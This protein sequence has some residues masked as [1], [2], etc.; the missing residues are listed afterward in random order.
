MKKYF[1]YVAILA[2]TLGIL[3]GTFVVP[4]AATT[5][6]EG[7]STWASDYIT[8]YS[9]W[10]N[11]GTGGK[12]YVYFDI[13]A[14]RE[15]ARVGAKLIVVQKLDAGTWK[16]VQTTTGTLSNGLLLANDSSHT[17]LIIYA[18]TP[19]N[20]YRGVVTVYSGPVSGGD[21]RI[22]TTN[23]VVAKSS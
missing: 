12:V 8:S 7:N 3:T 15:V 9:A 6:S 17:G 11:A 18:G 5:Q 13:N 4:A 10:T 14:T 2:C 16:P 19:G 1:R 21:S 22:I 20:T 23:S